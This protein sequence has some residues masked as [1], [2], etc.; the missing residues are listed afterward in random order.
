MG[1]NAV[2]GNPVTTTGGAGGVSLGGVLNTAAGGSAG[3][4]G[5]AGTGGTNVNVHECLHVR[6]PS[7]VYPCYAC[8][9]LPAGRKDGCPQTFGCSG[10]GGA[11]AYYPSGCNVVFDFYNEYYPDELQSAQC[12]GTVWYCAL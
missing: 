12:Q 7:V 4:P 9:P 11:Q 3:A 6:S 8:D 1:G 10:S 5:N 2:G